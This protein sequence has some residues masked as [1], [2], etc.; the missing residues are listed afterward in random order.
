MMTI[1]SIQPILNE[2]IARIFVQSCMNAVGTVHWGGWVFW[3]AL[4]AS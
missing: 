2:V 3:I 4:D 1:Y